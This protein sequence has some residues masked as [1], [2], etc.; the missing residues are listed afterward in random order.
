M[1]RAEAERKAAF[2]ADMTRRRRDFEELSA[3][4]VAMRR[5]LGELQLEQRAAG[6]AVLTALGA[7]KR[8]AW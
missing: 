7:F 8:C 4:F 3:T 1:V 5:E 2:R 6:S